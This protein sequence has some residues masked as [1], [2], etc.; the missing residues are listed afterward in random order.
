M[1]RPTPQPNAL[2]ASQVARLVD[3]RPQSVAARIEKGKLEAFEHLGVTMIPMRSV[4]RWL[5]EIAAR[6]ARQEQLSLDRAEVAS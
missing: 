6:R 4:R 5:E 3:V 1:P 2:I